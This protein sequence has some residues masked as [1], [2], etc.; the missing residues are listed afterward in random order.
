MQE[1]TLEKIIN[2]KE[3]Q[4]FE[5]KSARIKPKDILKHISAFAN[6]DGGLLVIGIEDSG[7]LSG[8]NYNGSFNLQDYKLEI[9]RNIYPLPNIEFKNMKIVNNKNQ[10][11]NIIL[12]SV[13]VSIDKI[14]HLKNNEEVYL[15]IGD[16]SIQ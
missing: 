2:K 13:D 1:Y 3:G 11:D 5:K 12:I 4:Y 8:T 16:K 14:I 10:I 9:Y 7:E 15:R 6:A